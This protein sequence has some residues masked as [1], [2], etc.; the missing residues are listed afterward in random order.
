MKL[1]EAQEKI[2]KLCNIPFSEMFTEDDF[3]ELRSKCTWIWTTQNGVKGY[4]VAGT[5]GNS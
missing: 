1:K 2:I 5:N 4:K 3:E